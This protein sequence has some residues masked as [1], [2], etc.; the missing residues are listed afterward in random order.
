MS[1]SEI[2]VTCLFADEGETARQIILRSFDFFL[3]REL[4]RDR[5]KFSSAEP[6]HA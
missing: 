5:K 3:Q 4:L 1:K 2:T 6:Y